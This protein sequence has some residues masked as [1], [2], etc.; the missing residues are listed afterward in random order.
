MRGGTGGQPLLFQL[1][2]AGQVSL[3]LQ[4][5]AV[6]AESWLTL[7]PMVVGLPSVS[8]A[9]VRGKLWCAIIVPPDPVAAGVNAAGLNRPLV[10]ESVNAQIPALAAIASAGRYRLDFSA[11]TAVE[12]AS[13]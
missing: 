9:Q 5:A 10:V 11:F 6:E 1:L 8:L 4:H 13:S 3:N 2:V 12:A 7:A